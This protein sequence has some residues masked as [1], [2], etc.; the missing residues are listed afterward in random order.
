MLVEEADFL[1]LAFEITSAFGTVGLSMG[2]TG[3]LGTPGELIVMVVMFLGR[4][5]PLTLGFFLVTRS[6]PRVRFPK[7]QIYI[8]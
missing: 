3:E 2:A 1:I 6:R 5:G 4:V 8:G 7:G